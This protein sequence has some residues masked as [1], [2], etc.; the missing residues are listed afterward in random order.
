MVVKGNRVAEVRKKGL[1]N[2][3]QLFGELAIQV[4]EPGLRALTLPD[5]NVVFTPS[6]SY[7]PHNSHPHAQAQTEGHVGDAQLPGTSSTNSEMTGP[8]ASRH[9]H[10]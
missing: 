2:L 6:D 1:L 10:A 5:L 4:Q 3:T 7:Q 8:S 9:G